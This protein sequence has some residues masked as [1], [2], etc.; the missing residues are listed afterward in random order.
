MLCFCLVLGNEI[1]NHIIKPET[2]Q[3]MVFRIAKDKYNIVCAIISVESNWNY[4]VVSPTGDYG[5]MQINKKTWQNHYDWDRILE[6]EYNVK[7]GI[8]ILELCMES[9]NQD[10]HKALIYYNG[11]KHYPAK[12]YGKMKK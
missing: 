6:P 11:S 3:D 12:I 7:V 1:Y 5:L 4:D 9:R 2:L 10:L 8:E